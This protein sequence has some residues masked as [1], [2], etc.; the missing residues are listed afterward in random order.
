MVYKGRKKKSIQYYAIK[1]VDKTQKPRVLQEVCLACSE[2]ATAA[3]V[4]ISDSCIAGADH[5]CP[6]AQ[7][8]SEVLRMV[9]ADSGLSWLQFSSSHDACECSVDIMPWPW[10]C[11]HACISICSCIGELY[12]MILASRLAAHTEQWQQHFV[13]SQAGSDVSVC[14]KRWCH[15]LNLILFDIP[16]QI[17]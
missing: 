2:R 5:A 13:A 11:S 16:Q 17:S 12:T 8:C 7:Q 3:Y 4:R 9:S 6:G 14:S 10:Q 1:S 15:L